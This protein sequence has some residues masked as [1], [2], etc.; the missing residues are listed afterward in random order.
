MSLLLRPPQSE[1]PVSDAAQPVSPVFFASRE[2]GSSSPQQ[3]QNTLISP[4]TYLIPKPQPYHTFFALNV[5]LHLSLP[6]RLRE[7][8]FCAVVYKKEGKN[9]IQLTRLHFWCDLFSGVEGSIKKE[10]PFW[11]L[12][13]FISS[14]V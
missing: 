8:S 5:W 11:T 3:P 14:P 4:A 10:M 1:G 12:I 2:A 7:Y 13:I 9:G 6:N